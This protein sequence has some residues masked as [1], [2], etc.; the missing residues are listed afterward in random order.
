MRPPSRPLKAPA[1]GRH[2]ALLGGLIGAGVAAGLWAWV[3]GQATAWVL[4]GHWPRRPLSWMGFALWG[5]VHHPN[6]PLWVWTQDGQAN[7]GVGPMAPGA[8]WGPGATAAFWVVGTVAL[9]V[10][11]AVFWCIGKAFGQ[12]APRRPKGPVSIGAKRRR[13][14]VP[15]GSS[16]AN[17][18]DLKPLLVRGPS[19]GRVVL[20]SAGRRLV[21]TEQRQSVIVIGPTQSYKT[22]G[23]AIPA[24]LEWE[25]PILAASVKTDLVAATL[26][27]RAKLGTT[28]VYDPTACTGLQGAGWSPLASCTDWLGA[29]RMAAGLCGIARGQGSGLA[30]GDFWYAT[31]AKLLAPLLLAAAHGGAAMGDVVR[32]VDTQEVYEVEDLLR[33]AGSPQALQAARANWQREDRQRS[34]VYT[35]AEVV[36]EAFADPP[37]AANTASGDIDPAVLLDG[38]RSALFICSPAWEQ[39][40]L[41]PLFAALIKQVIDLAYARVSRTGRPLDPPLL[42][43]IDEAANVAPLADLDGLASTAAGHGIQLVTVWQDMAQ[44]SARYGSRA[45]T[46]INNH[47]AKI[48]L[49]GI[50]DPATL[51][52]MSA[53]LGDEE[54][55][56]Q[57]MTIDPDG[58]RSATRAQQTKRLAPGAE[59]RRVRPGEG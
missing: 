29:R 1:T 38:G 32:W 16:W 17:H 57:S 15:S 55:M 20:G 28:W 33:D 47:R 39:Q 8:P 9:I 23:F 56:R 26:A 59:L 30:E 21:A 3:T 53:L 48:S 18:R 5:V 27:W 51:D 42:V 41:Q 44:I 25:G 12:W 54:V 35:T 4:T 36:V 46:V 6:H 22:S 14:V 58:R 10:V 19:R 43:V 37:V 50:A 40:R 52:H 31:A 24:L 34:S 7:F 13:R 45:A 11:V 2:D 49:S